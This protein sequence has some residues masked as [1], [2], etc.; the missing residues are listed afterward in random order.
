MH[1]FKQ[2]I[3]HYGFLDDYR[4]I[5][6]T[7]LI[8][9][10]ESSIRASHAACTSATST[11]L[12]NVALAFLHSRLWQ[13]ADQICVKHRAPTIRISGL[14]DARIKECVFYI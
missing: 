12:C 7:Y 10:R 6:K 4:K 8:K 3:K 13:K 9:G 11:M 2:M 5:C 14:T 1:I